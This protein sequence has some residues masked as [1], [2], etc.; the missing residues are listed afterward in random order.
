[1]KYKIDVFAL[2]T[3]IICFFQ[4]SL[5]GVFIATYRTADW[6]S[7]VANS[8]LFECYPVPGFVPEPDVQSLLKTLN[9]PLS[10]ETLQIL[11]PFIEYMEQTWTGFTVAGCRGKPLH[12]IGM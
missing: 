12:E 6:Y 7:E 10:E 2:K 8:H 3:L 5:E 4:N 1:M 11:T 9:E